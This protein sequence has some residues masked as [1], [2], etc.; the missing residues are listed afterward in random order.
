MASITVYTIA[1]LTSYSHL[2]CLFV[3]LSAWRLVQDYVNAPRIMGKSLEIPPLAQ[4]FGVLT[5]GEIA[6]FV[7]ALVSVPILATLRILW[8]R[9]S[10]ARSA[11]EPVTPLPPSG[12]I[13][14]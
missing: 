8:R 13:V 5:G 3:F 11:D 1:I 2:I 7:G 12:G 9:L 10:S 4:I 6:G 14:K